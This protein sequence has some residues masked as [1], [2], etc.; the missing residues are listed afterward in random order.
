MAGTRS[1]NDNLPVP[2]L[3][4][5]GQLGVLDLVLLQVI[6][7][8]SDRL[9]DLLLSPRQRLLEVLVEGLG[10]HDGLLS[11]LSMPLGRCYFGF[12]RRDFILD[13]SAPRD[14][15]GAVHDTGDS[16]ERSHSDAD[17]HQHCV[18]K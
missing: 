8:V 16:D 6:V 1:R 13:L 17:L 9:V 10:L 18:V 7:L 4:L 5:K 2:D 3:G 14:C 15:H 12:D 11:S